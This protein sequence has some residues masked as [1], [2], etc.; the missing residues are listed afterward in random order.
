MV[1]YFIIW[2]R[3]GTPEE[4]ERPVKN[5]GESPIKRKVVNKHR[6]VKKSEAH[7]SEESIVDSEGKYQKNIG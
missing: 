1:Y 7:E 3:P 4:L 5:S 6:H 2:Q